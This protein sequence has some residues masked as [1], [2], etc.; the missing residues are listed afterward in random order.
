MSR[1]KPEDLLEQVGRKQ[2]QPKESPVERLSPEFQKHRCPTCQSEK[3]GR[4]QTGFGY[5]F[6]CE[7][8]GF[9]WPCGMAT[10]PA[11]PYEMPYPAHGDFEVPVDDYPEQDYTQDFRNP[12]KIYD[13]E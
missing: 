12:S 2:Q 7:S 9:R 5:D 11:D 13:Y 8:C 10:G 3:V 4:K 1:L 6:E